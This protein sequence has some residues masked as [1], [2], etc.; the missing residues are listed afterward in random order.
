MGSNKLEFGIGE[1]YGLD[2]VEK[3]HS[4]TDGKSYGGTS[5]SGHTLTVNAD[6]SKSDGVA[7]D[8]RTYIGG[9][10]HCTACMSHDDFPDKLNFAVNGTF[11]ITMPDGK[12]YSNTVAVAQ[13]HNAGSH[14]NWWIGSKQMYGKAVNTPVAIGI[15][16][17]CDA[18]EDLKKKTDETISNIAQTVSDAIENVFN[19][20]ADNIDNNP[21]T[22]LKNVN[23]KVDEMAQNICDKIDNSSSIDANLTKKFVMDLANDIKKFI[24]ELMEKS[25]MVQNFVIDIGNKV[26]EKIKEKITDATS[27][28]NQKLYEVIHEII[29]AISLLF[30]RFDGSKSS[31]NNISMSIIGY[32]VIDDLKK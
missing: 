21:S 30:V 7:N 26:A 15:F 24:K 3:E 2:F 19:T 9:E 17:R 25:D 27:A 13:G 16:H 14:N 6:R 28:A 11:T 12:K 4:I 20:I 10:G 5:M 22:F 31:P 18:A 32:Q 23:T 29:Y 1:E 8:F